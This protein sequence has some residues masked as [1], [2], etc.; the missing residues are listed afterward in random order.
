MDDA[1]IDT[2]AQAEPTNG[3]LDL[4]GNR[5]K[6]DVSA[7]RQ[8]PEQGDASAET[9]G[10]EL[11]RGLPADKRPLRLPDD[12]LEESEACEYI[13]LSGTDFWMKEKFL[14]L[15]I[16]PTEVVPGHG[17]RPKRS[18][19]SA[20]DILDGLPHDWPH[21][22]KPASAS[23]NRVSV[24]REGIG[25]PV[26]DIAVSDGRRRVDQD[27]VGGLAESIRR[28]N[29]TDPILVRKIDASEGEDEDADDKFELIA[30]AHRLAAVKLL[31]WQYI[32]A[33]IT[34]ADNDTAKLMELDE[35]LFRAEL[36]HAERADHIA[37]RQEVFERIHGPAKARGAAAANEA[38]G[39]EH[40]A[41]AKLAD[42]FTTDTAK[43]TGMSERAVQRDAQR[44]KAIGAGS[45]AK[46]AGT[47]LDK[48]AE[49]D[50]LAK[51]PEDKR[52]ELI[53]Q[54]AG[55]EKVSARPARKAK[56]REAVAEMR[57]MLARA[58]KAERE[59]QRQKLSAEAAR[60][61]KEQLDNVLKNA[62]FGADV[63]V[64]SPSIVM[65][66]VGPTPV[67]PAPDDAESLL[68]ILCA[69]WARSNLKCR[70]DALETANQVKF[71]DYLRD[72]ISYN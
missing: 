4:P 34:K 6:P 63:V 2:A 45:L 3:D 1:A 21:A 49:L 40:D 38:M 43:A 20:E 24:I 58:D 53:E 37:R 71:L 32:D 15:K 42:A 19:W 65:T 39:R 54:A 16:P 14:S 18:L 66:D 13:G 64:E 22:I 60:I 7:E 11:S 17:R 36:S 23:V 52:A 25:I 67:P 51:L 12:L 30:G 9:V 55:G 35:N 10:A 26:S 46:I 29:L 8:Q 61:E 62:D 31:G 28:I 48:G 47:S 27:K 70:F 57:K 5:N 33:I 59:E 50:A 41:S 56:P 68:D 69:E 44:G 72:A